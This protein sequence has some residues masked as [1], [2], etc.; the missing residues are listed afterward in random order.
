MLCG[1]TGVEPQDIG[2]PDILSNRAVAT[3]MGEPQEL[4]VRADVTLWLGFFEEM[5]QKVIRLRNRNLFGQLNP[6]AVVPDLHTEGGRD[7]LHLKEIYLPAAVAGLIDAE[8][9]AEKV[10]ELDAKLVME[11]LKIQ[12]AEAADQNR[13]TLGLDVRNSLGL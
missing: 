13:R 2:F 11:R 8:T 9:F 10:P 4:A 7:W 6:D 5:F 3:E 12:R 1:L